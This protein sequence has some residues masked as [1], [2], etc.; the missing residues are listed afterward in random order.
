MPRRHACPNAVQAGAPLPAGAAMALEASRGA[1]V[2][3]IWG[4]G[5]VVGARPRHGR[6]E[7]CA[8]FPDAAT[9]G[10]EASRGVSFGW[11]PGPAGVD[12]ARPRHGSLQAG[13]PFNPTATM[14]LEAFHGAAF[15]GIPSPAAEEGARSSFIGSGVQA[16][17]SD[18]AVHGM[19]GRRSS[20]ARHI[21]HWGSVP[22][23]A[24]PELIQKR[25]MGALAA[26]MREMQD[27]A[28]R[29]R[30]LMSQYKVVHEFV[31]RHVVNE[32]FV[33]LDEMAESLEHTSLQCQEA[34]YANPRSPSEPEDELP[35][36]GCDQWEE[37]E[38]LQDDAS[39]CAENDIDF[40]EILD[41][42]MD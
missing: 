32:L 22:A 13:A 28:E 10:L 38:Y 16:G 36:D 11:I 37:D 41:R 1:F 33:K 19:A 23:N 6:L 24:S 15:G 42:R 14:G 5:G 17:A 9:M 29:M 40:E 8:P 18:P 30:K 26:C 31:P 39:W 21:V 34:L 27:N 35:F 12:G 25:T 3:G 7:G 2:D 4:P 20:L